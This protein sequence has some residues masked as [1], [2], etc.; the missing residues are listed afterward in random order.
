[1]AQEIERKFIVPAKPDFL[2]G[3]PFVIIQQGY[4]SVHESGMEV[5]I[6]NKGEA[7]FLTVKSD[8]GL[9]RTEVELP[10]SEQEFMDLWPFT[11]EGQIRKKRFLYET[12]EQ[13]IEIDVFEGKLQGLIVAEIEFLSMSLA[14]S[15][16]P[17]SWMGQEVTTLPQFKNKYLSQVKSL[18][19]IEMEG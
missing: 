2:D 8:G 7:Y 4:L 17:L 13:T 6:R 19:D 11:H 10:M 1:M 12:K 16:Q 18:S 9:S 14:E 5:R 3:L 15:F